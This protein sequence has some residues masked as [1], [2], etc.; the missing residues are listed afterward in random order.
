M[1][2]TLETLRG[3]AA[4]AVAFFHFPSLSLLYFETGHL[5]VYFFFCLSGFVITLNYFYR[6]KTFKNLL[7]FQ[8]RRFFR[9]YPI[10]ILV[11]F[12]VLIIQILKFFLINNG[13]SSGSEAFGPWYTLKDFILHLFLLQ[14]VV[15]GGYFLSWNSSAWSI[16]TEFYTYLIFGILVLILRGNKILFI[17]FLLIYQFYFTELFQYLDKIFFGHINNL[18]NDCLLPFFSGSLMFFIYEKVRFKINDFFLFFLA[19][20]SYY[21]IV[22]LNNYI[23]ITIH[24]YWAILILIFALLK[25]NSFIFKILNFRPF[26]YLGALS[27]SFYMIHQIVLYVLI[28]VFKVF[29]LGFSFSSEKASSTGD[30][31]YDTCITILYVLI[32]LIVAA[33][34]HKFIEQRFRIKNWN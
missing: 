23:T 8:I 33:F 1:I 25:K 16:S 31:F 12:I 28:Q 17:V 19:I 5:A 27:Y 21:L 2:Y 30:V 22:F 7:N 20:T 6:I 18:L 34:L 29:D 3:F 24:L 11:L 26:V 4:I 13:L 14:A 10:H 9:L 32:S 15:D